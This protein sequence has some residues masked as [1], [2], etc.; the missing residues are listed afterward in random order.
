MATITP[1]SAGRRHEP[2]AV[3]RQSPLVEPLPRPTLRGLATVI[4]SVLVLGWAWIGSGITLDGLVEGLPDMADFV[5]RL[6]P[7]NWSAARGAVGPLLETVQMAITGTAL[8]VVIA[9][10]LSLLAAANISPHPVIYQAFR[11]VLNVGRTIPE[12]VLA[13]AFVAAVGLGAFPGTL[14]LA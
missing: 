2:P 9:V 14:A 5:S 6:F 4:G 8:A 1:V 10:P 3:V 12:L 13:L 7:P 11:A